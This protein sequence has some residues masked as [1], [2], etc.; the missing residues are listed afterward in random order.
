MCGAWGVVAIAPAPCRGSLGHYTHTMASTASARS[1]VWSALVLAVLAGAAVVTSLCLLR[2]LIPGSTV[3]I[4]SMAVL[5]Y[6]YRRVWRGPIRCSLLKD[7]DLA[8]ARAGGPALKERLRELEPLRNDVG[9]A[10]L[11]WMAGERA[12]FLRKSASA[13]RK[14]K[15]VHQ[16]GVRWIVGFAIAAV[17]LTLLLFI[18]RPT[19]A[20]EILR[21]RPGDDLVAL[22]EAGDLV[23]AIRKGDEAPSGDVGTIYNTGLA[24][25]KQGNLGNAKER[26]LQVLETNPYY[27]DA[28]Y[29]LGEIARRQGDLDEAASR[30]RKCLELDNRL[31]DAHYSLGTVLAAQKQHAAASESFKRAAALYPEDSPW[32]PMAEREAAKARGKAR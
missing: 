1:L 14:G 18:V 28:H 30:F 15:A 24:H 7:A 26:F 9:N 10:D 20:A 27:V 22:L 12:A 4:V 32:K 2:L 3:Q 17:V 23:G 8:Y 21:P 13:I 11:M 31:A 6:L 25:M 5:W 19:L 16:P 29:N